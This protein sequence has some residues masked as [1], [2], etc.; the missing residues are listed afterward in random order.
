MSFQEQITEF[1]PGAADALALSLSPSTSSSIDVE[2]LAGSLDSSSSGSSSCEEASGPNDTHRRSSAGKLSAETSGCTKDLDIKI[3]EDIDDKQYIL[4]CR[5][6]RTDTKLHHADISKA[7]CDHSSYT[8]L[9][10]QY[11]GHFPKLWRLLSFSEISNVEFVRVSPK[12][13][14][15]RD[16]SKS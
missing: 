7:P 5:K 12:S 9:H 3:L 10:K 4:L 15:S 1:K 2:K 13:L 14:I 16:F 6:Y 11:Y 8:V